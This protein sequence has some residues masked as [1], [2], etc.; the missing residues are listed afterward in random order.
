MR[1]HLRFDNW[2]IMPELPSLIAQ[3][4]AIAA[5]RLADHRTAHRALAVG[6]AGGELTGCISAVALD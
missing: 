1:L 4:A 2:V 6:V 5:Q 3:K